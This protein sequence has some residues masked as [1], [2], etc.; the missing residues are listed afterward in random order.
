MRGFVEDLPLS[1]K[2]LFRFVKSGAGMRPIVACQLTILCPKQ[3]D[4][5]LTAN[6]LIFGVSSAGFFPWLYTFF[7]LLGLWVA[8]MNQGDGGRKPCR[9]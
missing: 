5:L 2:G 3:T 7:P 9:P 8:P 6:N 1:V 4:K